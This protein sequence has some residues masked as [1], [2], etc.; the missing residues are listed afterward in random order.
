LRKQGIGEDGTFASYHPFVTLVYFLSVLIVA[1]MSMHPVFLILGFTAVLSYHLLLRGRKGLK[2][3]AGV[4][5]PIMTLTM[6]INPLFNH[7]GVTVLFYLN[8]NQMT[9]EAYIYGLAAGTMMVTV[10]LWF[11]CLQVI[12]GPDKFIYLFGRV[13]PVTGLLISMVFRFIPLLK[14]RFSEIR[15]GQKGMG[16]RYG[17]MSLFKRARQFAK[18]FSILISWSLEAAIETSDS[19]EARGYG[20]HGRTSFHLFRFRKRDVR[21][22]VLILL[23]GVVLIVSAGKGYGDIYYY[24]AVSY[25]HPWSSLILPS[26]A[27][28]VMLWVP[29]IID[30]KGELRWKKLSSGISASP[31]PD[32]TNMC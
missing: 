10:L 9:L 14:N 16:M 1:M 23:L 25:P 20:L 12:M 4:A 3:A 17:K 13:I 11:A 15:E 29:F 18:E 30:V 7:R 28:A 2:F 19:M 31:T 21:L 22:L 5:V 8:G 27:Y 32:V 24:P 26:A 6:I